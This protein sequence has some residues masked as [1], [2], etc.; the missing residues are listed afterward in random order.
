MQEKRTGPGKGAEDE[1]GGGEEEQ[2]Q[3]DCLSLK[4][5]RRM[6]P[7]PN[8]KGTSRVV[9]REKV[10]LIIEIQGM[11]GRDAAS[12]GELKGQSEMELPG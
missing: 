4:R 1:D 11:E 10:K 2:R 6:N 7:A 3:N 12:G 8:V 9:T 5:R